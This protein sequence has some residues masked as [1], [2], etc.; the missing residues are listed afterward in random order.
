MTLP[1]SSS[2]IRPWDRRF[3]RALAPLASLAWLASLASL[4]SLTMLPL[5]CATPNRPSSLVEAK[6]EQAAAPTIES[7]P[8]WALSAPQKS[9]DSEFGIGSG[10]SLDEA[11]RYALQDVAS[12]LSVSVESQL[13]DVYREIDGTSA[14]TLEHVIETRVL[15]TRFRGWERTRNAR[16]EGVYWVEVRIDRRRLIH[17]S[18]LQL[19]ELATVIDNRLEHAGKSSLSQLLALQITSADQERVSNLVGLIDALDASFNRAEWDRRRERW[20]R[21]DESAR[22]SLVFEIRSDPASQEIARWLASQLEA[23]RLTT[24]PGACGSDE[25]ICIDIRSEIVEANVANRHLTQI[26]SSFSFVEPGGSVVREINLRGRGNSSADGDRARRHALDDL[27]RNFQ[28][29]SLLDGLTA[30]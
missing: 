25:A 13:R 15:N 23:N 30:N 19:N 9:D 10:H 28:S 22:R 29:S 4:T 24:R 7:V 27:R 26:R 3:P 18:L 12:R 11:T 20:Q 14:E 5:G 8:A 2:T 16:R 1:P 6:A 17:D 21:V